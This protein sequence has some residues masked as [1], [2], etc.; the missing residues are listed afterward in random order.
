MAKRKRR[1]RSPTKPFVFI[2]TNIFLDF[3]RANREA[4]LSLLERLKAVKDRVISTYQVEME[5]LKNRQNVLV[6]SLNNVKADPTPTLPAIFSDSATAKSVKNLAKDIKN[7]TDLQRKRI[8]NLLKNPKQNDTVYQ[9]L[10][11]IFQSPSDHVLTRDM[12]VRQRIKRLAWRRFMLGYPPRKK[13]DVS[14]G[15]ALNWEWLIHCGQTFPGKIIIVSR[16]GDY[17][18]N[19][20]NEYFLNDQLRHEYRDRVGNK[21]IEYTHLL[22]TALKQLQVAVP[23]DEVDAETESLKNT[24]AFARAFSE[25]EVDFRKQMQESI[26]QQ[27]D[28][29]RKSGDA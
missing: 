21:G 15:D 25:S 29:L 13:S 28:A 4:N 10:T 8:V 16:D 26:R 2:D 24:E 22:S 14:I 23:K 3:Y 1:K 11:E 9:V 27:I 6:E 17:G 20:K 7:K 18:A 19:I 5:F 12:D